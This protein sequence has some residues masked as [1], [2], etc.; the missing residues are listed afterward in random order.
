MRL[1]YAFVLAS[2]LSFVPAYAAIYHHNYRVASVVDSKPE[3][4]IVHAPTPGYSILVAK[5][6]DGV[7][8]K[9]VFKDTD[10]N[11][12]VLS[13]WLTERYDAYVQRTH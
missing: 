11:S 4:S 2:M 1:I 9:L 10:I 3:L 5:W 8:E 13:V 7:V 12:S 6:P